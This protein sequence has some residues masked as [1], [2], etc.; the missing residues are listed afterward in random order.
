MDPIIHSL[1][2]QGV[3]AAL[4][5]DI[6]AFREQY[7]VSESLEGRI[8]PPPIPYYGKETFEMAA[9]AADMVCDSIDVP[10]ALSW[11]GDNCAEF[12]AG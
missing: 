4:L 2:E 10:P 5:R 9:C 7:P 12:V 11:S 8:T 1:E 3:S 6:A